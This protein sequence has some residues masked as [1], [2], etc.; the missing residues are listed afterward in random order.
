MSTILSIS[1]FLKKS[2]HIPIIDVRS[3]A[4]FEAGHI[5]GAI[6]LPIFSNEERAKVGTLYKQKGKN[7]AVIL[8]LEIV[9]TKLAEFSRTALSVAK[10]N[11]LLVY[12]WRGGMRS[13]SMAWLFEKVGIE[14]FTLYGGYKTYRNH[15]IETF[16]KIKKL[17][18]LGG[19]TGSGKTEILEEI[20][21]CGEQV[22]N[23]EQIAHHKGSTFGALGELENQPS[24]EHFA[25]L[26]FHELQKFDLHKPIWVEDESK[27]IG[28]IHLPDN[29][30]ENLRTSFLI[31]LNVELNYRIERLIN[32]YGNF[33]KTELINAIHRISKRLGDK[34]SNLA[35]EAINSGNLADAVVI[36]LNYYDKTYGFG[37]SKRNAEF[38]KEIQLISKEK[39]NFAKQIIQF[40]YKECL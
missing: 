35:I 23:L 37:L 5:V 21:E 16:D 17:V 38:I 4:E 2:E 18:V 6:N 26:L 19:Y 15:I 29:F 28:T 39:E 3:P 36:S 10:Q 27:R 20:K 13:A 7:E 30:F 32:D 22:L 9:G 1:D 25:N 12:C 24:S 40:Y 11:Q 31:K 8:G 34:N 14:T 33:K